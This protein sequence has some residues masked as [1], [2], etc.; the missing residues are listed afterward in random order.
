[1][2]KVDAAGVDSVGHSG[3]DLE[4]NILKETKQTFHLP[5]VKFLR[6]HVALESSEQQLRCSRHSI[7]PIS[8]RSSH[9]KPCTYQCFFAAK[10]D[11]QKCFGAEWSAKVLS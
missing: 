7:P 3:L 6:S 2:S 9:V 5:V 8:D 1:M 4:A 10:S 11:L